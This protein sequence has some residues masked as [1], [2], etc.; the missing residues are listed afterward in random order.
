MIEE[1]VSQKWTQYPNQSWKTSDA[2]LTFQNGTVSDRSRRDRSPTLTDEDSCLGV[3]QP[4]NE[5][6]HETLRSAAWKHE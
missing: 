3:C 1:Y 4:F 6:S 2:F 5:N